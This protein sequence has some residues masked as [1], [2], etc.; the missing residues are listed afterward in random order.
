MRLFGLLLCAVGAH[1]PRPARLS[2]GGCRGVC[3]RC[4]LVFVALACAVAGCAPL[5]AALPPTSAPT[6][7]APD[8]RVRLAHDVTAVAD[9]WT[10]TLGSEPVAVLSVLASGHGRLLIA[11]TAGTTALY[12]LQPDQAVR[13]RAALVR[14]VEAGTLD[15]LAEPPRPLYT[16]RTA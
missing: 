12:D 1:L 3:S 10:L 15:A 16:T 14:A 11:R 5:T 6:A 2:S 13:A 4:G 7:P 8:G 9:V